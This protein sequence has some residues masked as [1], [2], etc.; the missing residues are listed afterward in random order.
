MSASS[1]EEL[2]EADEHEVVQQ[3]QVTNVACT[4]SAQLYNTSGL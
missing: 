2:A 1:L 3:V 4:L